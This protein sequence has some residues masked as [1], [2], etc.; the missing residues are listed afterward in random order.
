M[1]N[2]LVLTCVALITAL[3]MVYLIGQLYKDYEYSRYRKMQKMV[4]Q[5]MKEEKE[6]EKN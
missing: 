4:R 5:I 2:I 3:S 1:I 6:H